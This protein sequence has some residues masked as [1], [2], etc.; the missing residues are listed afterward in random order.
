MLAELC[1]DDLVGDV[2]VLDGV[3][4]QRGDQR[5]HIHAQIG[6]DDGHLDRMDDVGLAAF[7]AHA[8]VR[9][10]RELERLGELRLVIGVEVRRGHALQ[11]R[12]ALLGGLGDEA[13]LPRGARVDREGLLGRVGASQ[14]IVRNGLPGCE[15]L[16]G[17]ADQLLGLPIVSAHD[18][19]SPSP[20]C[21][22]RM[23]LDTRAC[24]EDASLSITQSLNVWY[25][26]C[27]PKPSR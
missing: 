20:A 13:R 1:G 3:V 16:G 14:Q 18:R 26:S 8:L 6:Q 17:L 21:L 9:L 7:A 23:G 27:S 2:G 19:F 24:S 4:Q 12:E 11:L 10:A 25:I 15:L 22:G 5:L